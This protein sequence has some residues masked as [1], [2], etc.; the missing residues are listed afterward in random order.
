MALTDAWFTLSVVAL[1][2]EIVAVPPTTLPFCGRALAGVA[3]RVETS[4]SAPA[5]IPANL[6]A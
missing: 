1:G 3:L 6:V 2:C 4:V 5:A